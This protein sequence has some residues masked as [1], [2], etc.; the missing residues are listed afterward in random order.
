VGPDAREIP[1][2][3][4]G[5]AVEDELGHPVVEDRVPEEL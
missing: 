1:L 4:L 2:Q 5:V 3:K